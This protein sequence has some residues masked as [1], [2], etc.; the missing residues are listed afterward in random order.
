ME[1]VD[2]VITKNKQTNKQTNKQK[3]TKNQNQPNKQKPKT[4]NRHIHI[5]L[6]Y[7][8]PIQFSK[9]KLRA[10]QMAQQ[11]RV[12]T[13]LP[14]VLSSIPSNHIAAHKHL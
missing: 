11:L 13:A 4:R 5:Y 1:K 8:K 14:E 2:I 12:Q 3:T 6:T 10:E 9:M 7:G